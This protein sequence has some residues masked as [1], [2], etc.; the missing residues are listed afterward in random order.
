MLSALS[1]PGE[2]EDSSRCPLLADGG[3]NS[4]KRDHRMLTLHR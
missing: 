4:T 1:S 2:A 3:H